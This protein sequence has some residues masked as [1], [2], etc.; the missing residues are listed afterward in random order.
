MLAV[1]CAI[2]ALISRNKDEK[3]EI[4]ANASKSVMIGASSI[5]NAAPKENPAKVLGNGA[6]ADGD[7]LDVGGGGDGDA[8]GAAGKKAQE[9]GS[10]GVKGLDERFKAAIAEAEAMAKE[11]R[12]ETQAHWEPLAEKN[13]ITVLSHSKLKN[14]TLSVLTVPAGRPSV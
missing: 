14:C 8:D 4:H 10:D 1:V 5:T 9:R 11:L 2:G 7:G 13:G 6:T 3:K 12:D